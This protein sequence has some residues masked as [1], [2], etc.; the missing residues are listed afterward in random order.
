MPPVASI[1]KKLV[2]VV[3]LGG[4]AGVVAY[5]MVKP[6]TVAPGRD[7][8]SR[9]AANGATSVPVLATRVERQAVPVQL[10][11]VATVRPLNTVTI[12][13]QVDGRLLRVAFEEGQEVKAGD[14]LAE[15]DPATY[16]AALDQAVAKRA[17]TE[18]QLDNAKHDYERMA[19]IP[20]VTAQK[21]VD[22]QAALVAQLKAQRQADDAAV[23]S[24]RTILGY[25]RITS[26]IN[27]RTG[28]RLVDAGNLVRSGDAGLV[29]ITEIDP[30][31]VLFTLPQQKLQDVRQAEAKGKV[32]V[33]ALDADGRNVIATGELEVI[34]NQIDPTTGTIRMK[35]RFPNPQRQLWPGQFVNVRIRI[36]TLEDV[37]AVPN[38]AIQRGPAGT[39]VWA[40]GEND[41][42]T[43]VPVE[44]GLTTETVAVV[45]KG[46]DAGRQV[47]TTGFARISEGARLAVQDAPVSTP[48]G[49]APPPRARHR[50]GKRGKGGE[51]HSRRPENNAGANAA[52]SD[53]AHRAPT[54][55]A[56]TMIPQTGSTGATRPS[57]TP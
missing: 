11:A 47:V 35:A 16:Q 12:K 52:A 23:D 15:I 22:T 13:P 38:V 30:I 32:V 28:L 55:N 42:A 43:I 54:A 48:V 57:G 3:L 21:T 53:K 6:P 25:T 1:L 8:P 17:V 14:L 18:T 40:V 29:T 26:P 2:A 24:A 36:D 49:F 5:A 50:K 34:D 33:E 44:T 39:F 45:T 37:I 7:R 56:A 4:M 46:L 19:K 9:G 10:E 27:G 20:G 31:A 51:G 41:T